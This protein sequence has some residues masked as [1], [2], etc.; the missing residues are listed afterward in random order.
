MQARVYLVIIETD[1]HEGQYH[2]QANTAD[3]AKQRAQ[4]SF[5]NEFGCEGR[6]TTCKERTDE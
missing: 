6:V 2:I 5:R 1:D 4:T 3:T